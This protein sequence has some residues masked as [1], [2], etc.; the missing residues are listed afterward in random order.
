M[1]SHRLHICCVDYLLFEK[2]KNYL[3]INNIANWFDI[4]FVKFE[5]FHKILGDC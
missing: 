4:I 5:L 2:Y 3:F 1:H